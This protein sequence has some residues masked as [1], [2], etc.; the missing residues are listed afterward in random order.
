MLFTGKSLLS[1][2]NCGFS[3]VVDDYIKIG[4]ESIIKTFLEDG[5]DTG[6][7]SPVTTAA[8]TASQQNRSQEC[9][10]KQSP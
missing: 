9:F 5:A 4:M 6:I 10:D 1:Y 7:K 8:E 2:S 3:N